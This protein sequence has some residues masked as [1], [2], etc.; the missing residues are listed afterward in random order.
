MRRR[1][2]KKNAINRGVSKEMSLDERFDEESI[3]REIARS[4]VWYEEQ[5]PKDLLEEARVYDGTELYPEM[6]VFYYKRYMER[7]GK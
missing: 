4:V 3:R 6:L 2:F 5:L 1:G 7:N